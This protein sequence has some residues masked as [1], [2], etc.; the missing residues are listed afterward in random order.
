MISRD[1]IRNILE[2]GVQAP[3]GENAQ[4]WRFGIRKN[5]I[6]L[7]NIAERDQSLYNFRQ[8]ASYVA[9]GALLENIVIAAAASGYAT[10]TSLFP[11]KNDPNHVAVVALREA[12]GGE[13]AADKALYPMI[14]KRATNRKPY[15]D[16]LLTADQKR[17]LGAA[18]RSFAPG[19]VLFVE[20]RSAVKALARVGSTN[21]R[22]ALEN[23][24]V[25][26]FL[27]SHIN[28]NDRENEEKKIGFDIKTLEL[29]APAEA[30]FRLFRSWPLVN[31]LNNVGLSRA[32]WHQN[33]AVYAHASAVGIVAVPGNRNEDF[34]LAGRIT[35]R[36]WLTATQLGLS[37]QP[38]TGILFF[39]QRILADLNE[40]FTARQVGLIKG[41]YE[42]V[43]N[44][45][46]LAGETVPMMF[47][48]GTGDPPTAQSLKLPPII[49]DLR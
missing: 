37:M 6:H 27:F 7:F 13:R 36:L 44:I 22:L 23:K 21:E 46:H 8:R 16:I 43:R 2:A 24:F 18:T 25:H 20:E 31:V 41:S 14:A 42:T 33:G 9:H 30:A 26:D 1:A 12:G 48:L 17:E 47:R 38:M 28:W 10:A 49:D 3:S 35:Q 11:D 19:K 4:Q 32:I 29:P 45:F 34:L 40:P 5:E 39:M 15:K